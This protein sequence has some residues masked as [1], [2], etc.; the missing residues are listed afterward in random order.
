MSNVTGWSN[1]CSYYV[2]SQLFTVHSQLMYNS[3]LLLLVVLSSSNSAGLTDLYY[4]ARLLEHWRQLSTLNKQQTPWTWLTLFG[5][6]H[7]HQQL[8]TSQLNTVSFINTC[9]NL[10]HDVMYRYNCYFFASNSS[11]LPHSGI[12]QIHLNA[13]AQLNLKPVCRRVNANLHNV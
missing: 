4:I 7:V 3:N 5:L 2:V 9:S 12:K 6:W 10:L 13:D 11:C 8:G 1:N